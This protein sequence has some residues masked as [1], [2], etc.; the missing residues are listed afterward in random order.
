MSKKTKKRVEDIHSYFIPCELKPKGPL[1]SV[2]D[3]FAYDIK[4]AF[5]FGSLGVLSHEKDSYAIL[6]TNDRSAPVVGYVMTITNKDTED[7]LE[8]IK[9]YGGPNHFNVH[10]KVL[11]KAYLDLDKSQKSWVFCLSNEVLSHY[12]SVEQVEDGLWDEEDEKQIKLLDI[13]D[14]LNYDDN[15]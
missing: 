1:W 13:I 5:I 14:E 15:K 2:L 9:G 8:K 11:V 6:E 12:L 7:L 4:P 3:P 10:N